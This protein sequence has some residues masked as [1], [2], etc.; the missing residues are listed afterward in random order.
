MELAKNVT[1][2]EFYKTIRQTYESNN[3]ISTLKIEFYDGNQT[4]KMIY[5]TPEGFYQD[6][7]QR[8]GDIELLLD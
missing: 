7:M 8:R 3:H 4:V 1:I 6:Q 5:K 2:N